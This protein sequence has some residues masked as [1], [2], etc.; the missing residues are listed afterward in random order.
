MGIVFR[1]KKPAHSPLGS[2]EALKNIYKASPELFIVVGRVWMG[3]YLPLEI[4][5]CKSVVFYFLFSFEIVEAIRGK[6]F[7]FLYFQYYQQTRNMACSST[8]DS[9]IGTFSKIDI[10][11]LALF[12]GEKV[13]FCLFFLNMS[14]IFFLFFLNVFSYQGK[15][16]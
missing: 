6:N 16:F 5:K 15:R 10:R 9:N 8:M 13:V 7:N 3:A 4:F 1:L 14:S 12:E 11:H 2:H